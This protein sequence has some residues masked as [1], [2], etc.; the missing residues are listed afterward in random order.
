M[1]NNNQ[2]NIN[3]TDVDITRDCLATQE[4]LSNR[5]NFFIPHTI[6]TKTRYC[7]L[8]ILDEEYNIQSEL[9]DEAKK[10]NWITISDKVENDKISEAKNHF[11]NEKI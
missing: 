6:D 5:Y 10:R 1:K 11:Y 7:L 4:Y 9:F 3:F 8:N 2:N